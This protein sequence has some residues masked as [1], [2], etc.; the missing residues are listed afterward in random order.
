VAK[1]PK[2]SR[3]P[4]EAPIDAAALSD[5]PLILPNE[6]ETMSVL[7]AI[8]HT[9][10]PKKLATRKALSNEL[11]RD[12]RLGAEWRVGKSERC[13]DHLLA[14]RD[15]PDPPIYFDILRALG[16]I[17][18]DA[19]SLP[20]ADPQK[21]LDR[22][23]RPIH[24]LD[25]AVNA[26]FNFAVGMDQDLTPLVDTAMAEAPFWRGADGGERSRPQEL[27]E[28]IHR[29]LSAN[30][31]RV[32]YV[33]GPPF[34]A[35]REILKGVVGLLSG[36]FLDVDERRLPTFAQALGAWSNEAFIDRLLRFY[37]GASSDDHDFSANLDTNAKI[38]FI[39]AAAHARPA[40]VVLAD[41]EP[42]DEDA[43]VRRLRGDRV[44]DVLDA[45]INSGHRDTRIL[46]G[47]TDSRRAGTEHPSDA[48]V[49][50][51]SVTA[52]HEEF[53]TAAAAVR[54]LVPLEH[55]D[56]D[57]ITMRAAIPVLRRVRTDPTVLEDQ[58]IGFQTAV[59]DR[60][61]RG[62]FEIFWDKI[63][64]P[65]D[66]LLLGLISSSHDGLRMDTLVAV[67]DALGKMQ[68][69]KP[70]A[71]LR[72]VAKDQVGLSA[73][74]ATQEQFVRWR[75]ND[76]G[77]DN[78]FNSTFYIRDPLRS[79]V[80][81][82]WTDS[83]ATLWRD[84]M[85]CIAR[86][87]ASQAKAHGL[88]QRASGAGE[89]LTL[90][91]QAL[92]GLLASVDSREVAASDALRPAPARS[93]ESKI[94]P[95]LGVRLARRPDATSCYRYAWS[96]LYGL[97][98]DDGNDFINTQ[99]DATTR[100]DALMAFLRPD[101]PWRT[102][103][104]RALTAAG[105]TVNLEALGP[106][107]RGL[108]PREQLDLLTR[109][110]MAAL[111][112]EEYRLVTDCLRVGKLIA[113]RERSS[114]APDREMIAAEDLLRLYRA[115]IDLR[116]LLAGDPAAK[117]PALRPGPAEMAKFTDA[118]RSLSGVAEYIA[119][120][121][122][123]LLPSDP[124]AIGDDFVHG[125]LSLRRAELHHL[126][127][128]RAEEGRAIKAALVAETRLIA[129]G[130]PTVLA[131]I[132]AGYGI[133]R[134]IRY[135]LNTAQRKG[136]DPLE[137]RDGL[138]WPR[139]RRVSTHTLLRARRLLDVNERRTIRGLRADRVA[140]L[141]DRC[142][143]ALADRDLPAARKELDLAIQAGARTSSA[144]DTVLELGALRVELSIEEAMAAAA[145]VEAKF[146]AS[147][148]HELM[149]LGQECDQALRAF[150]RLVSKE[151]AVYTA[152]R[153]YLQAQGLVVVSRLAES[154]TSERQAALVVA[155]AAFDRA[156]EACRV[157]GVGLWGPRAEATRA[158][159]AAVV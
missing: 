59:R 122:D 90:N 73:W 15:A 23:Q 74:Q 156:I 33:A 32:I 96:Q 52:S 11:L 27:A 17:A 115:E 18:L 128:E 64:S 121:M 123:E 31:K 3:I 19:M 82:A 104:R 151:L 159:V 88:R 133:R 37:A 78:R 67:I 7:R 86:E 130:P 4:V 97:D 66:Q 30:E 84:G 136:F 35:K 43:L 94:L 45:L 79:L 47:T 57:A 139:P 20:D 155:C 24:T 8:I 143:I 118:Q 53:D 71:A 49:A 2:L 34:S 116:L 83:E 153:L 1:R 13:F 117:S 25:G 108:R 70:T 9:Q 92:H 113:E 114:T 129:R 77:D 95:P 141:I 80:L 14:G 76:E 51:F 107:R 93:L 110:S 36:R 138:A 100:V 81:K 150:E 144:H 29:L 124:P 68:H 131:P 105:E 111:A 157:A 16:R 28:E 145:V 61:A 120:V 75:Q 112:A 5:L 42:F 63:C 126:R 135:S 38:A 21:L 152:R 69:D 6:R 132:T 62:V 137:F 26:A 41:V 109:L 89:A 140:L 158:A 40:F 147:D 12:K 55:D 106:A 39:R 56:L 58:V 119:R 148:R 46:L 127:G 91:I 87:A 60:D 99:A 101:A 134:L 154:G 146:R 50:V 48:D 98:I 149:R 22:I 54:D 72:S 142:Q 85:W 102:D 10:R 103:M 44:G 65:E 125:K